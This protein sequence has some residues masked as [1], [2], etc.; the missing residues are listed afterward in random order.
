[1]STNLI[2]NRNGVTYH[3][4]VENTSAILDT[5]YILVNRD[6]VTYKAPGDTISKGIST[7]AFGSA[8]PPFTSESGPAMNLTNADGKIEF[9]LDGNSWSNS[10]SVPAETIYYCIW[11]SDILS[12]AHNSNYETIVAVN[13]PSLSMDQD[14]EIKLKIDKLPDP[15][16]FTPENDVTGNTLFVANTISPL[17]SINAPTAIWGSSNATTPQIAIADGPWEALPTTFNTRYVNMNE[18]IRVRHTSG[19]AGSFNYDTTIN[20]GYGTGASE[21]ETSTFRTTT[22]AKSIVTPVIT[23]P[24]GTDLSPTFTTVT[25]SAYSGEGGAGTHTTSDWQIATDASFST[26]VQ[27]SLNDSSN[28]TTWNRSFQGLAWN[29]THYIRVRY[30]DQ[31]G[32]ISEW[33][34]ISIGI[35]PQLPAYGTSNTTVGTPGSHNSF[36]TFTVPEGIGTIRVEARG[37]K[38]SGNG[39]KIQATYTVWPKE[40]FRIYNVNDTAYFGED[41]DFS[42]TDI[43]LIAG[44]GGYVGTFSS[45]NDGN[46]GPRGGGG[47]G[48]GNTGASGSAHSGGGNS[49]SG[50]SQNSGG[51]RG[52][53]GRSPCNPLTES[54]NGERWKG[55]RGRYCN[56]PGDGSYNGG[57]GG[58]GWYGGGG[59]GSYA[60][61]GGGSNYASGR[62]FGQTIKN[63]QGTYT[64]T[65]SQ[66]LI[67]W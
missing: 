49:G 8:L 37:R 7:G 62:R 59:G 65:S 29:T 35:E 21:F 4:D 1:M 13:Y 31:F 58:A 9:S 41:A 40:V 33:G 36:T 47:A 44:A 55:G 15:F 56:N 54:E 17:G 53:G 12:A 10:L 46:V 51:G 38:G 48:G 26:I 2:V 64:G 32:T 14:V 18:R 50:G 27:E 57:A 67:E 30:K 28:L 11:G 34:E 63:E 60:G 22:A 39:G 42:T 61:G 52:T 23:S 20:I 45:N 19:S 3:L 6:G 16:S 66:V 25:A 24:T 43:L 5:D